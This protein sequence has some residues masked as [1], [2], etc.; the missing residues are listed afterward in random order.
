[1]KGW[2]NKEINPARPGVIYIGSSGDLRKRLGDHL[3][4]NS[5]N[6]LLYSQIAD[7]AARVRYCLISEAWRTAERKLYEVFCDTFGAPPPCN[8]M[9]P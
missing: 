9:S 5:D 3:R 2:I 4:G 1:M 7:G 8:R 6:M